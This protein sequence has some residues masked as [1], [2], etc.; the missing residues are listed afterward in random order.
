MTIATAILKAPHKGIRD[1]KGH[2][3]RALLEKCLVVT[4]HG[5]PISVNL[6]YEEVM[7]L[8]DVIDELSDPEIVKAVIEGRKAIAEGAEGISVSTV[9]DEVRKE[10]K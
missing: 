10:G 8:L 4:D 9:F 2:L 7:E 5:Q 6:P 1:L 3:S